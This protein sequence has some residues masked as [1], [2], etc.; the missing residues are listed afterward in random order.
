MDTD[1]PTGPGLLATNDHSCGGGGCDAAEQIS[2]Q[3]LVSLIV[4]IDLAVHLPAPSVSH[5]KG[6]HDAASK[7]VSRQY[8]QRLVRSFLTGE[9]NFGARFYLSQRIDHSQHR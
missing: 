1:D 2:P 8:D 7:A 3:C 5:R 9:D 6:G 4:R